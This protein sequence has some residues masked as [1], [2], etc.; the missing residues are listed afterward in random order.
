MNANKLIESFFAINDSAFL[1]DMINTIKI[2]LAKI[3][4]ICFSDMPYGL[5]SWFVFWL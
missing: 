3:F 1:S 4:F 5:F 2:I